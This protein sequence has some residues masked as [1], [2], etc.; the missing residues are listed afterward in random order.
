MSDPKERDDL[1]TI[2][3]IIA[4]LRA[5]AK[6]LALDLVRGINAYGLLAGMSALMAGF[7]LILA[8][9][10]LFPA[11]YTFYFENRY[12]GLILLAYPII[13]SWVTYKS[14]R[15]YSSFS[16]KYSR[17]IETSKRLGD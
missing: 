14:L 4:E 16:R 12:F 10:L 9:V 3:A 7:T 6:P 8:L 17:L 2:S 11:Y 5:D 15:R 1:E 13:G